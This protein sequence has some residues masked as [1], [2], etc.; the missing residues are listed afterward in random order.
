MSYA[1]QSEGHVPD[2]ELLISTINQVRGE[3]LDDALLSIEILVR[4]NPTFRLA[5]LVYGDLLL[6]KAGGFNGLGSLSGMGGRRADVSG[7]RE[8]A[9]L[10]LQHHLKSPR[11]GRL[12]AYLLQLPPSQRQVVLVDISGSRLYLF[13]NRD[14]VPHLTYDYYVSTGRNGAVKQREGDRKTPVGV[15]FISS[16]IERKKLPDFYGAGAFPIDYPNPWDRR[17]GKTGYGIWLHGVPSD[18]YSRPPRA[19]DG[20]VAL[21]NADFSA[22]TPFID[23]GVTPVVIAEQVDWVTPRTVNLVRD[24]LVTAVER[25]RR[26]WESRDIDR[27]SR[28]YSQSFRSGGKGHGEWLRN[29]IRINGTKR[30][31]QVA[32]SE[33]GIF[34]DPGEQ[35]LVLITFSQDYTSNN[36]QSQTKKRQY[37]QREQDG[38]WRIVY[39][40][41][42]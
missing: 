32:I 20:C 35:D 36:Y 19:S 3:H 33:L 23:V 13:E 39:E 24:E 6:A 29:K 14:G 38:I 22:I 7:L 34:A 17:Q 2:E 18:T 30:Y 16:H 1:A 26:D 4:K 25:W 12:P 5:Q 21:A 9:R 10:R 40:G 15:Y 41:P 37:W 31:I 42:A 27:Y 28:N 11:K 8:E